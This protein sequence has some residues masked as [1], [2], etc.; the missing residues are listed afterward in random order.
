MGL[1]NGAVITQWTPLGF[2]MRDPDSMDDISKERFEGTV[3][4]A[5]FR[6]IGKVKKEAQED[7]GGA[8]DAQPLL[9]KVHKSSEKS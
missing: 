9:G 4:R 1:N 5:I 7:G 3:L 8:K 2:K 6:S